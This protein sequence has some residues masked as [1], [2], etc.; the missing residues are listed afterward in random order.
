[1]SEAIK[2]RNRV[3][4]YLVGRNVLD[5][6]VDDDKIVPW[7]IGVDLTRVTDHVNLI[8][9]AQHLYWFR[10]CSI[11]VVNS[12]HCLE[13]LD[14]TKSI[15]TEWLRVVKHNGFLILYLPHRDFYPNIGQPFANAGH[16]HDFLPDDIINI[17]REI[18]GNQLIS[19]NTYGEK[20]I[21]EIHHKQEY[22][23]LLIFKKD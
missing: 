6:G 5:I 15:L 4:N 22:S 10:D 7:A 21:Q 18:G 8:G 20:F 12:S 1:M 2:Y 13:D 16:Q 9:D 17:M 11:D 3:M 19:N 14:D 23:F